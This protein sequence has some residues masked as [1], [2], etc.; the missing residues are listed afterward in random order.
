MLELLK[1]PVDSVVLGPLWPQAAAKISP[2]QQEF[3]EQQHKNNDNW[4]EQEGTY[5]QE[6]LFILKVEVS[7][8]DDK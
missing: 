6:D 4:M 8:Q 7:F 3:R 5:F 2:M 1:R